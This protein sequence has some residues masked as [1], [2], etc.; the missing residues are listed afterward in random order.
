MWFID[1]HI[2]C[3]QKELLF[4]MQQHACLA[5]HVLINDSRC[6]DPT[7]QLSHCSDKAGAVKF[8]P[9]KGIQAVVLC[10]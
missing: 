2:T 1:C 6:C 8:D 9:I 7:Q 3:T 5:L 4:N 10:P